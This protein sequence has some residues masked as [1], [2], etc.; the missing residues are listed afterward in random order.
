MGGSKSGETSEACTALEENVAELR[1]SQAVSEPTE[2]FRLLVRVR[3]SRRLAHATTHVS[4]D[5]R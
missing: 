5:A 4:P 2:Q 3:Y 1:L